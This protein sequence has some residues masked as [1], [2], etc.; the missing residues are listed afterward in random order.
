MRLLIAAAALLISTSAF[1]TDFTKEIKQFDG[2]DFVDGA[3]KP[4]NPTLERV[5]ATALLNDYRDEAV[6]GVEKAK[7]YALAERIIANP[8]DV[9]LSNDDIL[10]LERLVAKAYSPWVY[11]SMLKEIAPN[12]LPK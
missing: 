6:D 4:A 5:A 8:H 7:R 12:D 2:T 9:T 11:G 1:A 10:R 3:G